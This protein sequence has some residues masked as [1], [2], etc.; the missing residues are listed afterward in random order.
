VRPQKTLQKQLRDI[1]EKMET[2]RGKIAVLD[3]ALADHTIYSEE[4]KK[5]ADFARLRTK[6]A[7]ELDSVETDWLAL[8]E[9]TADA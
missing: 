5:A 9:D 4:P 3:E 6:L 7:G 2:L 1:E 8:H